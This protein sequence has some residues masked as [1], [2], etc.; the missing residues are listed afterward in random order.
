MS[1]PSEDPAPPSLPP[2]DVGDD[3]EELSDDAIGSML[4][5]LPELGDE[6]DEELDASV[7]YELALDEEGGPT[8]VTEELDVGSD[9][10]D[11]MPVTGELA[12]DDDDN[13]G[14]PGLEI[15]MEDPVQPSMAAEEGEGLDDVED[16]ALLPAL[17]RGDD[18]EGVGEVDE[19]PELAALGDEARPA[20]AEPAWA[21]LG[22]GLELESC[23]ALATADGIVVAAS[24]DL[25][26]FAAGELSH[27]RLEAGSSRIHS[28]AL[29]GRG[30]EYAVCSTSNGKLFR[31]GRLASASEELRRIRETAEHLPSAREVF[32]L[33]QPGPSFPHALVLRT[34]SGKLL[35]SDDDGISF[36]R[37]SERR[38][39]ALA[40]RG[41]PAVA[42]CDDGTL[43]CS[44]DGGGSFSEVPLE[45]P[46]LDT[47]KTGVPLLAAQAGAIV[48][49]EPELGVFV[50]A[51]RG[52]QFR[53]VP[54][55]R[56]VTAICVGQERD[57]L[58]AFAAIYD[59][60]KN[61][62]WL[63]RVTIVDGVAETIARIESTT[64]DEEGAEG[65]RTA[66]LAWDD[67]HARLWAAGAFGVKVFTRPL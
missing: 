50:S 41:M 29:V 33:C 14:P 46:A 25:F 40:P 31:R 21:E 34:S 55:T 63:L 61:R 9:S 28:L 27:V 18:S 3:T 23:G 58:V 15:G 65:C 57:E 47:F 17:D 52:R 1:R 48:L 39:V 12:L 2:L 38:V 26:W 24:S 62:S 13:D 37:V 6:E 22:P 4:D 44:E 66:R 64:D 49:A 16:A 10:E 45:A 5:A 60:A 11:L 56:D 20:R 32:E 35:R 8:D 67:V 19:L 30:W 54:G 51:D 36:R 43:L 53:R 59:E 7:D 42:L